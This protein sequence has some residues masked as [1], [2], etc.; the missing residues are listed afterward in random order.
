V[1]AHPECTSTVITKLDEWLL[2]PEYRNHLSLA[3]AGDLYQQSG[4]VTGLTTA[5]KYYKELV[6][7][8]M[9][10]SKSWI[11]NI[12]MIDALLATMNMTNTANTT[13]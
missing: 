9:I 10:R 3:F 13:N 2:T 1:N 12:H 6:D 5:R 7:I 11:R 4:N 8:D